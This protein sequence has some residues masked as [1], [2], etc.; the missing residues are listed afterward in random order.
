VGEK[1]DSLQDSREDSGGGEVAVS[2][3]GSLE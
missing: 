3:A 1:E 2:Q